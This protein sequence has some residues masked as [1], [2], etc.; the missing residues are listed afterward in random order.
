MVR[1]D[2]SVPASDYVAEGNHFRPLRWVIPGAAVTI[3]S[4]DNGTA[5]RR[6]TDA[7]G[8]YS[9]LQVAPGIYKLVAEKPGFATMT[10]NKSHCW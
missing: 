4:S 8:E 3:E 6:T 5:R 9:F 10:K 1:N 2:D 7:Q